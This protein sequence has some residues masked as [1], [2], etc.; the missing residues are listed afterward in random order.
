[1]AITE[2]VT[3]ATAVMAQHHKERCMILE[4]QLAP[5]TQSSDTARRSPSN[6]SQ[7][8]NRSTRGQWELFRSHRE[9]LERLILHHLPKPHRLLLESPSTRL[10]A[11]GA[12]NCNDLDLRFL[13]DRIG[14]VHLVDIDADALENGVARQM[15]ATAINLHR[16][17]PIDLTVPEG[18]SDRIGRFDIVVSSCVLSQLIAGVRD[19]LGADHPDFPSQRTKTV[20][21]HLRLMLQLLAPGGCAILIND[22][23]STDTMPGLRPAPADDLPSLM[24]RLITDR[25]TFRGLDPS[26]I[27][28]ALNRLSFTGKR[29]LCPPWLWHLS[30]LRTYLVYGLVFA[31]S[32]AE[33][34]PAGSR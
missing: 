34:R 8:L 16:H 6:R 20:V 12:G 19:R 28:G 13:C 29:H 1:L 31:E 24:Q 30:A 27:N 23:V 25:K 9:R 22:L 26:E 5:A 17:A 2:A 33:G 7:E 11:L 15:A 18:L 32:D 10:C 14:E 3:Q 4:P 21:A